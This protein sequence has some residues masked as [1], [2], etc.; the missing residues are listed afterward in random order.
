MH[1][2]KFIL[3]NKIKFVRTSQVLRVPF[4]GAMGKNS[5]LK[6]MNV[7]STY[8]DHLVKL[9]VFISLLYQFKPAI[10]SFYCNALHSMTG[11]YWA[12]FN[13]N[14]NLNFKPYNWVKL[15]R[16]QLFFIEYGRFVGNGDILKYTILYWSA[17]S[18]LTF[19]CFVSLTW[20]EKKIICPLGTARKN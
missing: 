20:R 2:F 7:K 4:S 3:S 13:F 9:Y 15:Y 8:K 6:P 12:P 16:T 14:F 17:Q 18:C 10:T 11:I 19:L 5:S 1:H